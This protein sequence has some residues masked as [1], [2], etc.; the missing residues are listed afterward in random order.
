MSGKD[1]HLKEGFTVKVVRKFLESNISIVFIVFSILLGIVALYITPREEEPQIIVPAADIIISYP[2]HSALSVERQVTNVVEKMMREIEGVEY[3]HSASKRGMALVNVRFYVGRDIEKSFVKIFKKFDQRRY[4]LPKGIKGISIRQVNVDDVPV[5]TFNF[6]SKKYTDYELRRIAEEVALKIQNL[7][8]IGRIDIIGGRQRKIFIRTNPEKMLAYHITP[9]NIANAIKG[10]N[11]EYDMGN[12]TSGNVDFKVSTGRFLNS[13]DD[14]K[15]LIV[16][17]FNN[18]PIYLKDVAKVIDGP[19]EYSEY[20]RY[21]RGMAF[22]R[23]QKDRYHF[24]SIIGKSPFDRS[25]FPEDGVNCVTMSV[26]KL[27]GANNV[28]VAERS[29]KAIEKFKKTGVIPK[30]VEVILS[31]NY[32][33]TAN[34]KVKDLLEDLYVAVLVVLALLTMGLGF[35]QA[36]IVSIAVPCVFGFTLI[37]NYLFGFSIN[38]VVLFALTVALGLLVDDPIVDVENIHRHFEIQGKATRKIVLDAV[39]EIRPPLITATFAVM[40]SFLPLLFVTEMMGS[41]L[42]PMAVNVPVT[43]FMSIVVSFTITPYISY[44]LLKGTVHKGAKPKKV[45]DEFFGNIEEKFQYKFFKKILSPFLNSKFKSLI[46][47]FVVFLLFVFS[48]SLI[49]R[50]KVRPKQLPFD[51]KDELLLV[52]D[53]PEGTT[54]EQTDRV[55]RLLEAKLKQIPEVVDFGTYVGT[56]SPVDFQGLLRHYFLRRGPNVADIRVNIVHKN[57][58]RYTSHAFALRIRK[59]LK[60][61]VAGTKANLKIVELPPGPPSMDTVVACVYGPPNGDYNKLIKVSRIVEK[62]MSLEDGI[63]DLD[64]SVEA[65]QTRYRFVVDKD[66]AALNGVSEADISNT[67]NY[68]VKGVPITT[69]EMPHELVP[70][71]IVFWFNRSVRSY[72]RDLSNIFVKNKRGDL[73]PLSEL[74]HWEKE[75]IDKTIYHRQMRR[76]VYIYSDVVGRPPV[77]TCIDIEADRVKPEGKYKMGYVDV[78]AVKHERPASKRNIFHMGAGIHWSLPKGYDVSFSDEGEFHVTK[79]TFR[80]LGKAF[81]IAEMCIYILLLY[82]TGSFLIPLVIMISIPLMLIGVLPG[83]WLLN[84]FGMRHVN[85]IYNP[86]FLTAPAIIGVIALSGIVTRNAIIIVDFIHLGLIRGKSLYESLINSCAV[87]LRPILL[88]SGAAMLGALPITNDTVFGGMAWSMIFGLL[89]STLFSLIVIPVVY[90]IIYKNKKHHGLPE[91]ILLEEG[92]GE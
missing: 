62:R 21:N 39:N 59:M 55:C 52:V 23:K 19:D 7:K 12:E 54:L 78:A 10:M 16:G 44:H 47:L 88:T 89:A 4:L 90:N 6:A 28:L 65:D 20:V 72:L 77:E 9:L 35:R 17:T 63:V 11:V 49:G 5:V 86:Y 60:E 26:A 24:G 71:N 50:R 74:G 41:Y 91:K 13:S 70:V 32:G 33:L 42:R 58:R 46:L 76:V 8:N 69:V 57:E 61:A 37:I 40:F 15:N 66:K 68:S 2:G 79:D 43:M 36:F 14:L 31:R 30:D 84:Q 34:D 75:K 48:V 73:I 80:D 25:N 18:S 27:H 81:L 29:I 1:F 3:I 51:N 85:G 22:Y 38:R 56:H 82:Q 53:M 87:R 67:L 45:G 92:E 83:F 64:D